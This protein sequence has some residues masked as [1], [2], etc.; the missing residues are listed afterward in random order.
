MHRD[1]KAAN[2][3]IAAGGEVKLADFGL[4]LLLDSAEAEVKGM[5]G[6]PHWMAPEVFDGH[7]GLAADL[8]SI[9]CV[10]YEL[11]TGGPP[12]PDHASFNVLRALLT[13]GPATLP[14]ESN[15]Q[16]SPVFADFLKKIWVI[17]PRKRPSAAAM[18]EHPFVKT[19]PAEKSPGLAKLLRAYHK[20][21][22]ERQRKRDKAA[23]ATAAGK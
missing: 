21:V 23:A 5:A 6:T 11:V 8:W 1:V 4:A 9:G 3:L 10:A 17:N 13:D 16:W 12:F 15:A 20:A 18:L 2:I 22:K 14:T 7:Y 19:V